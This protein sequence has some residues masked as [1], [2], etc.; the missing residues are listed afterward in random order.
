[1]T[2]DHSTITVPLRVW[3]VKVGAWGLGSDVRVRTKVRLRVKIGLELDL[4]L[5]LGLVFQGH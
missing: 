4:W 5:G 1:M 2:I 3:T